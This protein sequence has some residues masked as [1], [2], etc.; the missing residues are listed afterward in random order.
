MLRIV[1]TN[2]DIIRLTIRSTPDPLWDLVLSIHMLRGQPGDLLFGD[3][4]RRTAAALRGGL[5]S[6]ARLLSDLIPTMGYFP[7]FLN[8]A[9]ATDGLAQGLETIRSTPIK[10][11]RNDLGRLNLPARSAS[12]GRLLNR[13]DPNT[14]SKLTDTMQAYYEKAI[15]PYLPILEAATDRDRRTRAHGILNGGMQTLLQSLQPTMVYADGELRIPHHPHQVIHLRGRGLTL[16]PS[17]FCVRHPITLFDAELPPVL[18][19]PCIRE[20]GPLLL[21][22]TVPQ[23]SLAALIG[24]TRAAILATVGSGIG[25]V[26][27]ARRLDISPANASEHLSVLRDSSLITSHR[28]GARV[29]H[30]I[31]GLGIAL[32][33]GQR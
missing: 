6:G 20:P 13:G 27:L 17:Y 14:L 23:R 11:L 9:T 5:G 4:R 28:V 8:P 1:F 32:M 33:E 2:D 19:Y 16:V 24:S 15:L 18:I 12:E 10:R 25:T 22:N 21:P 30:Q 29:V 3:W 7:D 31:A 26:E